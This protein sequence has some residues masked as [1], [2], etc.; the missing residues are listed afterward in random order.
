MIRLGSKGLRGIRL[1]DQ[2]IYGQLCCEDIMNLLLAFGASVWTV[3]RSE[4]LLGSWH[5]MLASQAS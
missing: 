2:I 4:P 3:T 1:G 5:V